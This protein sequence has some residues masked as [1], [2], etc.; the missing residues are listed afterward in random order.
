MYLIQLQGTDKKSLKNMI[1]LHEL[2]DDTDDKN[3]FEFSELKVICQTVCD[4]WKSVTFLSGDLYRKMGGA[5]KPLAPTDLQRLIYANSFDLDE[6]SGFS[7]SH[8]DWSCLTLRQHF[9][10]CWATLK[11]FEN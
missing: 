9:R 1:G 8:Q 4:L 10:Q 3:Y 6:T 11:H 7:S 2:S 5:F